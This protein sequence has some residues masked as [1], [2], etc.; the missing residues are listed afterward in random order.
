MQVSDSDFAESV[1]NA[2]QPVLV[3]FWASWCPPCKMMEPM[4][5]RLQAELAPQTLVAKLN[6]DRNAATAATYN[7]QSLPTF[8]LFHRG[9]EVASAPERKPKTSCASWCATS[10]RKT[11]LHRSPESRLSP[12]CPVRAH[13]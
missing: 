4:V 13:P 6:V 9:R 12:V 8:I 1:L 7:I 10:N 11:S 3:D 2:Q 5:D